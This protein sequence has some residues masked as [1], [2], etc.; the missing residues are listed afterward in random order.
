MRQKVCAW[1]AKTGACEDERMNGK[2]R[3]D[4]NTVDVCIHCGADL[5]SWQEIND[6][7]CA[8]CATALTCDIDAEN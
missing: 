3:L 5:T 4:N 2:V 6:K 1:R 7:V 8:S